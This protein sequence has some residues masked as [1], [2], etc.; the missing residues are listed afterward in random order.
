MRVA[1][2]ACAESASYAASAS[3]T[4]SASWAASASRLSRCAFLKP[5]LI[6]HVPSCTSSRG[7]RHRVGGFG[8][9][10]KDWPC[11]S[12]CYNYCWMFDASTVEYYYLF[13]MF[14]YQNPRT[15]SK[16]CRHR[17][18]IWTRIVCFILHAVHK[19]GLNVGCWEARGGPRGFTPRAVVKLVVIR[20]YAVC[21]KN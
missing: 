20:T 3:W 13:N 19:H 18:H 1:I 17:K 8:S 11:V 6:I 4:V 5:T 7:A 9:S 10:R 14:R 12:T 15:S 16:P 21:L 2:L